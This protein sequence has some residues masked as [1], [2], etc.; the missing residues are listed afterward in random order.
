MV[1]LLMKS[2]M[3]KLAERIDESSL[4][5]IGY[6]MASHPM[7]VSR[8]K[9]WR[10][11]LSSCPAECWMQVHVAAFEVKSG[12]T[13]KLLMNSAMVKLAK[14]IEESTLVVIGSAWCPTRRR[15]SVRR[16]ADQC[17][18]WSAEC[19]MQADGV[20]FEEPLHRGCRYA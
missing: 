2:A 13:V 1:K 20:S 14:T 19:R 8:E 4:E 7:T 11:M 6:G 17:S 18:L 15:F 16:C 5:A 9:V 3:V 10:A 12:Y